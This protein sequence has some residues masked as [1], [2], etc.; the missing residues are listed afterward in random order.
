MWNRESPVE[1]FLVTCNMFRD[2]EHKITGIMG[3]VILILRDTDYNTAATRCSLVMLN[4][5]TGLS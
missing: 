4:I 5:K 3:K 1:E 2:R